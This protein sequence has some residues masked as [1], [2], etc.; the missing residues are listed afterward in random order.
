MYYFLTD[1]IRDS[2]SG[3]EVA[4]I[5]RLALFKEKK[6][7]AKI[8]TRNFNLSQHENFKKFGLDDSDVINLFDYLQE[9]VEFQGKPVELKDVPSLYG[10]QLIESDNLHEYYFYGAT[11]PR[12]KVTTWN[13]MTSKVK[14]VEHF[15]SQGNSVQL[16]CYDSRG[17]LSLRQLRDTQGSVSVEKMY[18][19]T[20][21]LVYVS[22]YQLDKSGQQKNSL[23]KVVDYHGKDYYFNSLNELNTF[24]YD[25]I[26]RQ[27]EENTFIADLAWEVD[28]SLVAMQTNAR[29]YVYVHN[30]HFQA[31]QS[32]D[33]ATAPFNRSMQ[34]EV[35]HLDC[36][37]GFIFMTEAQRQDFKQRVKA[38]YETYVILNQ[39]YSQKELQRRRT[40]GAKKHKVNRLI[41]VSRIS[42]QKG[43]ADLVK[44]IDLVHQKLPTVT[45]DIWGYVNDAKLKEQ[46]D[47]EIKQRSLEK[48]IT[49]KGFQPDLEKE[50][51]KAGTMLVTS[52]FEGLHL[53]MAEAQTYGVPVVSYNVKYGPDVI[54]QNEKNGF[55]VKEHDIQAAADKIISLM[56]DPELYAQIHQNS[57]EQIKLFS[58]DSVWSMWQQIMTP[59]SQGTVN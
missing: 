3:I 19:P 5:N 49:F 47:N 59:A 54:I 52:H 16:D 10:A 21:K 41:S 57:F 29:V 40:V 43:L 53:A 27:T 51:K 37:N 22:Y 23:L 4:M 50:Y 31:L 25:E 26:N 1:Q 42:K 12:L 45:M 56:S 20:G 44:I 13:N 15:D 38:Q 48:V 58:N 6:V 11:V 55:L 8:L 34:Y 32:M 24:F 36:I 35:E 28:H 17:F 39:S 30:T 18:T 14:W 33:P 7:P 2:I 9:S 46:L